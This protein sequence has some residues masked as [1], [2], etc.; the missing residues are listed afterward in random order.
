MNAVEPNVPAKALRA[1]AR[2]L[3]LQQKSWVI[4]VGVLLA[5][6][7]LLTLGIDQVF[8]QGSERLE[9]QW[10]AESARRVE[11]TQAAEIDALERTARNYA[12]WS[13]TYD[14]LADASLPYVETN[15]QPAA[16]ANLQL[17]AFLLFDMNGAL[18]A[19]RLYRGG[20]V[21]RQGS[22][23][24]AEA[25]RLY[26]S[27]VAAPS[28]KP[29]KG[30][31]RVPEGLALVALL[32]VQRDDGSGST[33]GTLAQVRLLD[34]SRVKR[35]RDSVNLNLVLRESLGPDVM[36]LSEKARLTGF[37]S[38]EI[39]DEKMLVQVPLKDV[40][41]ATVAVWELTLARDI[42]LQGLQGRMIFLG[43]LTVLILAAAA[44]M[45]WML[46]ILV[47]SRLEALHAAV[48]HVSATSDLSVRLSLKGADELTGVGEG[49]NHML[50]ALERGEA[51]RVTAEQE[52]ERLNKQLQEAQKL[53]AIG[54]LTGRLAHDFMTT[55]AEDTVVDA[56]FDGRR[57]WS[58]WTLRDTRPG[59]AGQ[60][61]EWPPAL[62][63]FL[64]GTTQVSVVEHVSGRVVFDE[65][66]SLGTGTDRI[67]VVDRSG[68]PLG[69]DKSNRITTT[70][71]TRDR[72]QTAP[73]LDATEQVL[74]ALLEAGVNAFPVYGTLLGAIR[75]QDFIGHDSDVDLGYVSRHQHPLD[76]IRESYR[77]HRHLRERGF[78]IDR[79]SAAAFK[80]EV[81]EADGAVRGLD[82]FGGYFLNGSL[83]LMGEVGAS[84]MEEWVFPLGTCSFAGRTL[85]APA[86]PEKLLEA[87][88]GPNWRVPDPAF[89]FTTPRTTS[90]RLN[91]WF[92]GTRVNRMVWDGRFRV[93][94]KHAKRPSALAQHVLQEEG[95][96]ARVVDVGAGRG[97]DSLWFARKGV[98]VLALDYSR[99]TANPVRRQAD[100]EGLD[101]EFG[102]MNLL[103]LRSVIA[104]GARVA[105]LSG[106][107]TILANHLIDATDRRGLG[108]LA[109][110][111]RMALSTGGRM[112]ADFD[113]LRPGE[114]AVPPGPRDPTR[115]KDP[116][117]VL[118]T[119]RE[120]G[121][122]IVQ[123]N[124][125][126]TSEPAEG[127][128]AE[129]PVMRLVAEW[130]K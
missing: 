130:R 101:L 88:Y 119:L 99:R 39:D 2:G 62:R 49:I 69:I 14:F 87:T 21:T 126:L 20:V 98:P 61:A 31:V 122:V 94:E 128:G 127:E 37:V 34:A 103:E 60:V 38:K 33:R 65:E 5:L 116:E 125:V 17:D 59:D 64:N 30:V 106:P 8:G 3:S 13:D 36:E 76:V 1:Q 81:V 102:W 53:E 89:H 121:A 129:R 23:A 35:F 28:G 44:L 124:Q 79:Y 115:P 54:T 56:L 26:A 93:G 78:S 7:A 97:A 18:H 74:S 95:T 72:D 66:V 75:E 90:R 48:Q 24:M 9:E 110:F 92:R 55:S 4:T 12:T 109:R 25:L 113:A 120:S 15:L 91:G 41:G 111:A 80:V 27:A 84:F 114:R 63:R 42:H 108:A 19:G 70:F 105:R 32:P 58:F 43:V 16:F 22:A 67:V 77:L 52:R 104:Q 57:I 112:Y 71:D 11:I 85:P 47:I 73:L 117:R 123:C 45:G 40:R 118:Q 107:P 86:R 82:V 50:A 51:A 6:A 29:I 96:V 100:A 68:R 10:V 46:R 83:Y